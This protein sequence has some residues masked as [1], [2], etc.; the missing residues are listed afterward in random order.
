MGGF[1]FAISTILQGNNYPMP[2]ICVYIP[3]MAP[4]VEMPFPLNVRALHLT[5]YKFTQT[6]KEQYRN[7]Y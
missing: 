2:A 3:A 5:G 1:F 6:K 7:N 4:L